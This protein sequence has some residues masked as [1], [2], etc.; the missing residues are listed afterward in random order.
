VQNKFKECLKDKSL[1]EKET[2]V[3][4]EIT[5]CYEKVKTS[6]SS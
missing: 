2:Y 3:I 5:D 4:N 1:S 6:L